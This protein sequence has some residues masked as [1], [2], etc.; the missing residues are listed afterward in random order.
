MGNFATLAIKSRYR[1]RRGPIA[2]KVEPLEPIQDVGDA[3]APWLAFAAAMTLLA[4]LVALTVLA[5]PMTRFTTATA[6]QLSR[7][8]AYVEAVLHG[9]EGTR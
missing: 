1:T 3:A 7:P 2:A 4:G 8:A 6:E 5:G 9:Q